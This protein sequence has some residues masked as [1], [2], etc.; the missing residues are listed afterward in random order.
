MKFNVLLAVLVLTVA[1]APVNAIYAIDEPYTEV[2]HGSIL[3][4]PTKYNANLAVATQ[5]PNGIIPTSPNSKVATA[6]DLAGKMLELT[7]M[8]KYSGDEK[9]RSSLDKLHKALGKVE[10]RY[11]F[12]PAVIGI[13][14]LGYSVDRG[15]DVLSD[16]IFLSEEILGAGKLLGGREGAVA[17]ATVLTLG[18]VIAGKEKGAYSYVSDENSSVVLT[19]GYTI[20]LG[21]LSNFTYRDIQ[22]RYLIWNGLLVTQFDD[23]KFIQLDLYQIRHNLK[24]GIRNAIA[25]KYLK[26]AEFKRGFAAGEAE[27]ARLPTPV[28]RLGYQA[29]LAVSGDHSLDSIVRGGDSIEALKY[30]RLAEEHSL[31]KGAI[32]V[33]SLTDAQDI[34]TVDYVVP[35][36]EDLSHAS[37]NCCSFSGYSFEYKFKDGVPKYQGATIEYRPVRHRAVHIAGSI[38]SLLE[39]KFGVSARVSGF[40]ETKPLPSGVYNVT[41]YR[42]KVVEEEALSGTIDVMKP[43]VHRKNDV[44]QFPTLE[45]V[46]SEVLFYEAIKQRDPELFYLAADNLQIH[47]PRSS[48]RQAM[49]A[50]LSLDRKDAQA[51]AERISDPRVADVEVLL[52]MDKFREWY[53][54]ETL[55]RAVKSV[56]ASLQNDTYVKE[57]EELLD[58]LA[59]ESERT[60]LP[61][62]DA[63]KELSRGYKGYFGP[64]TKEYESLKVI[65]PYIPEHKP[66]V[67]A[68][69][70]GD[71]QSAGRL[72]ALLPAGKP[73]EI[74]LAKLRNQENAAKALKAEIVEAVRGILTEKGSTGEVKKKLTEYKA[75][76]AG[77]GITDAEMEIIGGMV[78]GL[79]AGL[80]TKEQAKDV[81]SNLKDFSDLKSVKPPEAPPAVTKPPTTA[82]ATPAPLPA[83]KPTS[84]VYV[85]RLLHAGLLA[86]VAA[87]VIFVLWKKGWLEKIRGA[88]GRRR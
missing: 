74:F 67:D 73:K 43:Q 59:L 72:I 51:L 47:S 25:E 65:A 88:G 66:V 15:D 3:Y 55:K 2:R 36:G 64:R 35:V 57:L 83:A 76:E 5:V 11:R 7:V 79:D 46:R 78:A 37:S 31:L 45:L 87:L 86:S 53:A 33:D 62:K 29:W 85:R 63:L 1:A 16:A 27:I 69:E 38:D 24:Q 80:V 54:D 8:Y 18:N 68:I 58:N 22:V 19:V 21:R 12:I 61:T 20:P 40:I 23:V 82:I 28:S 48:A 17:E 52:L 70:A 56:R 77:L 50:M 13:D 71:Y 44:V 6:E 10:R 34:Y 75:L 42:S 30:L 9:Y 60:A 4:F 14:G 26:D 39:T 81:L 41:A 49:L 32:Y 84:E